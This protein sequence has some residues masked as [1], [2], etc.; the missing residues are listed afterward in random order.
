[1]AGCRAH[2]TEWHV[3]GAELLRDWRSETGAA[4]GKL[5]GDHLPF[6]GNDTASFLAAKGR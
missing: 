6:A 4:H 5:M 3:A 1:M 2:G